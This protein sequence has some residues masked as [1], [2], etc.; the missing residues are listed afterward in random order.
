[1]SSVNTA[2]DEL[3]VEL[4]EYP[5]SHKAKAIR[6][7]YELHKKCRVLAEDVNELTSPHETRQWE[8]AAH[9]VL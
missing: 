2:Y 1:M 4:T 9:H 8:N 3:F 7:Q 5:H 6:G